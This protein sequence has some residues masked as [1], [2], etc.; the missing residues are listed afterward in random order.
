MS[1]FVMMSGYLFSFF[2]IALFVV[3]GLSL[4]TDTPAPFNLPKFMFET[5]RN[6]LI[7]T[8]IFIVT[9]ISLIR[10]NYAKHLAQLFVATFSIGFVV[11]YYVNVG[12]L[13]AL[14]NRPMHWFMLSKNGNALSGAR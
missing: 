9:A 1:I 4:L 14:F 11:T 6:V 2:V 12:I 5:T 8:G 3:G 7:T 10:S 13:K